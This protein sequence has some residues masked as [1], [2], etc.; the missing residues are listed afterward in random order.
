MWAD[1]VSGPGGAGCADSGDD[2][3][4]VGGRLHRLLAGRPVEQT[5]AEFA[6]EAVDLGDEDAVLDAEA[7]CCLAQ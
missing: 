4:A 6:F 1:V 5:V 7:V 3:L 2:L